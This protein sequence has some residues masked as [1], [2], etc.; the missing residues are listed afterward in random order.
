MFESLSNAATLALI[1][2]LEANALQMA[3]QAKGSDSQISVVI[4]WLFM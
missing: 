1:Q 2:S 4:D 3:N